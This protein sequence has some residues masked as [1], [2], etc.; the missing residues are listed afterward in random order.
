MNWRD[1]LTY[2][3][4]VSER[5]VRILDALSDFFPIPCHEDKYSV[6]SSW[7]DEARRSGVVTG[8]ELAQM[9]SDIAPNL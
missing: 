5:T 6:M 8:A 3:Q 2:P 9:R 7:L 1:L 4:H